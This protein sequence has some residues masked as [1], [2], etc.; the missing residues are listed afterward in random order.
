M[1][2]DSAAHTDGMSL[3]SDSHYGNSGSADKAR[4]FPKGELLEPDG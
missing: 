3:I 2:K 4:S 1:L